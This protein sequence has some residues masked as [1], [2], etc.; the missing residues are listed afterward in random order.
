MC[1]AKRVPENYIG[2]FNTGVAVGYP[3]WNSFGGLARGLGDMATRGVDLLIVVYNSVSLSRGK[4]R[5]Q[6]YIL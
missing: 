5:K 2:I 4:V 6:T 3:F 1:D